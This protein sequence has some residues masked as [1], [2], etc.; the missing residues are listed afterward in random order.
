MT[1]TDSPAA[2]PGHHD[3]NSSRR[4]WSI[5]LSGPGISLFA[6]NGGLYLRQRVASAESQAEP[7]NEMTLLM[8]GGRPKV[9]WVA[10]LSG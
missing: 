8:P 1:S 4:P 2:L 5:L 10:W 3:E 7:W 6:S 9:G